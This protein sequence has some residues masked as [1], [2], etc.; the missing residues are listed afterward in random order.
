MRQYSI[1]ILPAGAVIL[2]DENTMLLDALRKGGFQPDAPC[3]GKGTCG[4]CRVDADGQ[5]VLAC[6][7]PITRDMTVRLPEKQKSNILTNGIGQKIVPDGKHRYV[8]AI[9]VGTTTVVTFLLDGRSGALLS[10]ASMLNPQ[11]QFGADVISRIQYVMTTGSAELKEAIGQALSALVVEA[12]AKAGITPNEVTAAAI[13]GNTA[14]HHLMLG[15]DPT[16]MTTPPYMPK[17]FE[18]LSFPAA[19]FLPIAKDGEIRILPNIAGFV[20]ADTVGCIAATAFDE[21]D[22]LTLM[23]DIGTNGEMVLG[24]KNRRIACSTAAGPAFEGA[25]IFCGMRGAVGAIDKVSAE[26]GRLC[27]SVIGGGAAKGICGS[28]LLDAVAVM[29]ELGMITESGR[30][31]EGSFDPALWTSA[32]GCKAVRLMDDVVLTQKDVREVQLAKAAL[33]AG[34]ELMAKQ[35]GRKVEQIETVYLAGAF[36]NYLRP[37]SA[38]AIGLIPPVLLDWIVPVGNAAGE[39][40]KMS[41][42]SAAQFDRAKLLAKNTEFLELASLAEFQDCFVDCLSFEEDE[43]DE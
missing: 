12:C 33:R 10:S 17:V 35:L 20:G 41:A 23:I 16:S 6:Q 26:G 42:L 8:I 4:K 36:G 11:T 15:I 32:D 21:R 37:A 14:M 13:V 9:D 39:G 18:A 38:C 30:M 34:I 24:D 29:L 25:K 19:G 31:D 2:A 1:T 7:T 27:C 40:A 3:G 43:D 28:G 5:T 22:K